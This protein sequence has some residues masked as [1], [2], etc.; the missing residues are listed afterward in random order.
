MANKA[1]I[2]LEIQKLAKILIDGDRKKAL[3]IIRSRLNQPFDNIYQQMVWKGWERALNRQENNALIYQMLTEITPKDARRAHL[4]LKKKKSE[5]LIRDHT[6]TDL[7]K[8]YLTTWVS[9]LE[10]YC[11]MIQDEN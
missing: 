1:S 8:H 4:D 6:Q 2:D 3:S 9:L 7:S 11:N 10:I 5:I